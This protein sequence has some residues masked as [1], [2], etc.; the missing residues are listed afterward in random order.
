MWQF[1]AVVSAALAS[2]PKVSAIV[3]RTLFG[4]IE[5][6][7]P[8]LFHRQCQPQ[9][10]RGFSPLAELLVERTAPELL[11]ENNQQWIPNY[12]E[13]WIAGETISTAFV[14]SRIAPPVFFG[15]VVCTT[16]PPHS[17]NS[18]LPHCTLLI[19]LYEK[20]QGRSFHHRH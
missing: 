16:V 12:G 18:R 2:L 5:L 14:E 3:Y 4:K 19:Q 8:R 7:S 9:S 15:L 11:Y 1:R 17:A 20:K 6:S 10:I 13:L